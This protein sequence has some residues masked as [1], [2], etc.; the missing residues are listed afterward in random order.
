MASAN[1]SINIAELDFDSI[2]QNLK[3]YLKG[4]STFSDYDFESSVLSTLLDIL[5]YNTHYNA[6]YMNMIANEMFLDT[7]IKRSSV[8]SHAKLLNYTPTSSRAAKA[9]LNIT[10]NNITAS[11]FTIP[12]YTKF[13]S[14]SID[15]VNYPFITLESLNGIV[16][17]NSAIFYS[18]P[19][20]QGQP[21]KYTYNYDVIQ[22][23]TATFKLPDGSIDTTTLSVHVYDSAQSTTFTPYTLSTDHLVLDNNSTVYFLQE[24]LDGYYEIYFG[25][26]ILGKKLSQG[27]VVVVEYLISSGANPNGAY[28]FTLM[29]KIGNYS[30][31]TINPEQIASGGFDKESI[32]SI[33][34]TAPKAFSAQNRAVT[35]SDYI[36]L[37]SRPNSIIPIQTVNVWGGEEMSPPQYG[38]MFICIKPTGGY[39]LTTSQKVRLINEVITPF[40]VVTVIP[41]IVDIDYTFVKINTNILFSKSTSIL[42]TV[43][44]ANLVKLAIL[45]FCSSTLDTFDSTFILPDLITAIKNVDKSIISNESTLTL[46]KRFVPI[47]NTSNS[48]KLDFATP[49]KKGTLS[50]EYF[51]YIDPVSSN[52]IENVSIEETPISFN[53]IQS[54]TIITSGSGYTTTPI[55]TIYG[56]GSGA[57]A[58]AT[59]VNGKVTAINVINAGKNYTQAVA[60]ISEGGG[61]G[62][63]AV[64]ILSGSIVTLRTFYYNTS[65]IKVILQSDIGSVDYSSG[66]VTINGLVPYQ[67]NN[68]LGIMSVSVQPESSI[69]YSTKDKIITLDIM[70]DSA[71]IINVQEK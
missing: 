28:S 33:K 38:K 18:V 58:S 70:D 47:F 4:Q 67:I 1:S 59:V 2:K 16:S 30:S 9:L 53:E 45:S 34:Y 37:L 69:F 13:Y 8:I 32:D 26:G 61:T 64:P 22:N 39:S 24:S 6:Y 14:R 63:F 7:A 56:D 50:S 17:G 55:V 20:Y 42:G 25:D 15:N 52:I 3:T 49:L 11:N 41:E 29:D 31:V 60:I 43:Q 21:V 51:N 46:Q 27:N 66:I 12:K 48:F 36:E 10:F 40:S 68:P 5:S 71:I 57:T 44:L 19:V 65:G 35:K 62:A 54:F 23:P